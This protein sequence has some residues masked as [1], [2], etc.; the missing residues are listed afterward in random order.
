MHDYEITPTPVTTPGVV[1]GNGT[2]AGAGG[3]GTRVICPGAFDPVTV[4]VADFI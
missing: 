4:T 2:G 3:T 1:V